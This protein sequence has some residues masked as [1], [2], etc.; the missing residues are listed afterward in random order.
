M[1][2][3]MHPGEFLKNA[4]LNPLGLSASELSKAI[5][6]TT[7]TVS[8]LLSGKSSV[9]PEMAIRLSKC[10]ETSPH[11]WMK[12]QYEYDVIWKCAGMDFSN[13][14]RLANKCTPAE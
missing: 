11:M 14:K 8:R 12:M 7:A 2:I 3:A 9:S 5:D 10:F 13:V 4:Y 1:N 6:V